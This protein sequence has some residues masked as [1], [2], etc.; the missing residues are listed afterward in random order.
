[1]EN[2]R[3]REIDPKYID[4]SYD[5]KKR[6]ISYWHQINEVL[7]LDPE[8]VLEVGVGHKI[9]TDYLR[10]L[11]KEVITVD[12]KK[13]YNPLILGDVRNIPLESNLV[14]VVACFEVLEHIPFND[15]SDVLSELKR[16]SKSHI[17]ISVPDRTKLVKFSV[18]TL[19]FNFK[20][21]INSPFKGKRN[22]V[23]NST[24]RWV[25]GYKGYSLSD[26][27]RK[28]GDNNLKIKNTF[29]PFENPNHRF[30]VLSK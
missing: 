5:H 14:D 10:K 16:L 4:F 7:K 29:R 13:K 1:M 6:F 20:K 2:P 27:K 30:F 23:S 8:S 21:I 9:F 18:G 24:T 28:I 25:I 11:G 22:Y 3:L 26:I 15:F 12:K 17:I 19:F